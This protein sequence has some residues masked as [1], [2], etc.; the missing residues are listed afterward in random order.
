LGEGEIKRR[1]EEFILQSGGT[2]VAKKQKK[3]TEKLVTRKT[4]ELTYDLLKFGNTL[5][6]IA[7]ERDLQMG[8]ILEHIQKAKDSGLSIDFP[9][10]I[11]DPEMLKNIR[12]AYDAIRSE[13]EE[14]LDIKLVP[15]KRYLDKA[16]YEYDFDDI[17]FA[18]LF[19]D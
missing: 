2:L 10:L 12:D 11:I 9:Q 15:I 3:A 8:T 17:K 6:E 16:G 1:H 5:K 18:R 14:I 19:I 7:K 13:G 4:H